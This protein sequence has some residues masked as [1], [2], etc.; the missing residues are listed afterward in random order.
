MQLALAFFLMFLKYFKNKIKMISHTLTNV[1]KPCQ[2]QNYIDN[3][4]NTKMIGLKSIT[5]WVGW[6]NVTGKQN[7][8][9]KNKKNVLEPGLYNFNDLR[10]IFSDED[11]TLSA[12]HTNGFVTLEI[13]PNKEIELS[14]GIS[15]LLGLKHRQLTPGKHTG[16]KMIDIAK[17]K[18]L[19]VF[20]D[21][22]NATNNF[23]DG[24]PSTLLG[25]VP[26]SNKPFGKVVSCRFELPIFKKLIN[27]C[28]TELSV[29]IT[30]QNNTVLDNHDLP[31]IIEVLIQ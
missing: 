25:I 9:I 4:D 27:G 8:A 2:L 31:I 16:H 18:E 23:L 15:S 14:S 26:V 1:Q 24:E 19:R 17:T 20:L 10:Q 22:I 6:Y 5:Y 29:H 28:I 13:P 11:I 30:D 3:R 21:Q 12:N 7:L